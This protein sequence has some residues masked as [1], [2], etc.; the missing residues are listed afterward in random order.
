LNLFSVTKRFLG[1][2]YRK[3]QIFNGTICVPQIVAAVLGGA[4]LSLFTQEGEVPPEVN[5]L[6]L[7]GVFLVIGVCCVNVIKEHKAAEE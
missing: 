6:F 3:T 5:M 2:F 1:T 7:T 4:I